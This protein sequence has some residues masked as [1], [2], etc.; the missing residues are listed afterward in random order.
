[1]K[2]CFITDYLPDYHKLWGGAETACLRLAKLLIKNNQ[3][4]FFLTTQLTKDTDNNLTIFPVRTCEDINRERAPRLKIYFSW[5]NIAS[6]YA[7]R[8]L[9][10]TNPDIVHL[11]RFNTLSLSMIS[12]AKKLGI[13]VVFSVY[14]HWCVC[15]KTIL[16][17][18]KDEI[19]NKYQ[20]IACIECYPAKTKLNS[21]IKKFFFKL[22][23]NIFK[24][25]LNKI[26]V[27]LVLSHQNEIILRKFGIK[28]KI[29]C[30][31][32]PI[33]FNYEDIN[34]DS[35]DKVSILYTG[36]IYSHKGLHILIEA[37]PHVLKVIPE[38]RLN[39][40]ETGIDCEYKERILNLI[41]K[42]NIENKILFLERRSHKEVYTLLAKSTLVVVPEQW[43]NPW[44]IFITEAMF[45]GKP[46]IA[47]NIGGIPQ[48][49]KHGQNGLLAKSDDALDFA[50]NIIFVLRDEEFARR[51]GESAQK[52]ILEICNEDNILK[53]LL[54][55]YESIREYN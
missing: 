11:H 40:V 5:D 25:F 27:F 29:K 6:K 34:Y 55:I 12:A 16:L 53:E 45:F 41:N 22:R 31:A 2:I 19:C 21:F 17:N 50:R 4:V 9:K 46:V 39:I 44:P 23:G 1:M 32:L 24:Y 8:I 48:L 35:R 20:G 18:S 37:M 43:L 52:D 28:R 36:W 38:A 51:L 30:L 3:E 42:L 10:R 13:P 14:D 47:S 26:D 7:Y 15:P 33:L 49:I 54:N